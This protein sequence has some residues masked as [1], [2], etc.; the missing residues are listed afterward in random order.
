[1][2]AVDGTPDGNGLPYF[3]DDLE[4]LPVPCFVTRETH[5]SSKAVIREKIAAATA[6]DRPGNELAI[7][8]ERK[9]NAEL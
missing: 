1:M 6:G 7:H 2:K 9:G 8:T 3:V 4:V 5:R